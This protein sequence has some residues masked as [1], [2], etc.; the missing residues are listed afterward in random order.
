MSRESFA[1]EHT[2]GRLESPRVLVQAKSDFRA[3]SG[4]DTSTPA[5]PV[6]RTTTPA[7][8]HHPHPLYSQSNVRGTTA[9]SPASPRCRPPALPLP[10]QARPRARDRLGGRRTEGRSNSG[11]KGG[12]TPPRP[13]AN[14]P[15]PSTAPSSSFEPERC[16]SY[17]CR[18]PSSTPPTWMA[19]RVGVRVDHV[20]LCN[21]TVTQNSAI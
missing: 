12:R 3:S 17:A 11:R 15:A 5:W 16:V 13:W 20:R 19:R 1:R 4:R 7:R 2:D 10:E 21:E 18:A 9:R 14:R 8:T 6:T